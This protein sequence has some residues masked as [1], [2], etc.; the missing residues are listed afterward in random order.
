VTAAIWP[1]RLIELANAVALEDNMFIPDI[2]DK[3]VAACSS[4]VKAENGILKPLHFLLK[5]SSAA[6]GWVL[7]PYLTVG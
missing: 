3:A 4:L 5:A 2:E 1:I 7:T 6:I